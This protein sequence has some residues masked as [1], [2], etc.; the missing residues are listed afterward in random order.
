MESPFLK[1]VTAHVAA[2]NIL[3]QEKDVHGR[4]REPPED[5]KVSDFL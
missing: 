2:H 3:C 1:Y 4:S 5:D